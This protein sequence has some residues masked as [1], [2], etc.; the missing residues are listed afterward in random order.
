MPTY[1]RPSI[2]AG[3]AQIDDYTEVA[4]RRL[5]LLLGLSRFHGLPFSP[6]VDMEGY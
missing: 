5:A 1:T 6:I 4:S 2:A 3:I